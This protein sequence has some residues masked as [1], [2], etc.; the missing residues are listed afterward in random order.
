MERSSRRERG[1]LLIDQGRYDLAER[2]LREH[3][4]TEPDDGIG[5]ALLALALV[6][7]DR[8][9]DAE[10]EA[11]AAVSLA[12][13]A[14]FSHYA[15]ARTMLRRNAHREAL[16]AA[17][18]VVR[19]DPGHPRGHAILAATQIERRAYREALDAADAGLALAPEHETLL[20]LRGM[21]LSQLGRRAESAEAFAGA[22]QRDP[23]N[24]HAHAGRGLQLLHEG[25]MPEALDAFRESLRLDPT[26]DLAR[27]GLVEA[28]KARNP[29]YAWL[30][31]ATL[32][33]GRLSLPKTIALFV[34]LYFVQRALS[35]LA[36]SQPGL[37]PLVLPILGA[38]LIFIWLTF[39]ATP[40]FNLLLRLDPLGR[41]ALTGEQRV[42]ST[43]VGPLVAVGVVATVVAV[44]TGAALAIAVAVAALGLVVPIASTFSCDK[45]WPRN[46]MALVTIGIGLV[47][48]V[49]IVMAATGRTGH[50]LGFTALAFVL[51]FGSTW[52]ALPLTR[53]R[54]RR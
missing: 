8:L 32:W 21:A 43:I 39:A 34:G 29:I 15:L 2:E 31:R 50:A 36:A 30:L 17:R 7:L 40:M 35:A 18:E 28:L 3:L 19:L 26:N 23:S 24:A 52:L 9:P 12:P 41:H 48:V 13:D 14:A 44:V 20:T 53:V 46:V 47:A 11:R 1:G 4:A 37:Q 6:E 27:E 16:A 42:E 5:H 10:R 51:F 49:A 45:G 54:T 38:Y 33:I 25:R 22:L